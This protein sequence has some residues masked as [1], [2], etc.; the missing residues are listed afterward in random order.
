M[1]QLTTGPAA[2]SVSD[3]SESADAL[4]AATDPANARRL[5]I[6]IAEHWSLLA[7]RSLTYN[8]SLSRVVMFLSVVSAAVVALAL[9][10]QVDRFHEAVTVAA[11][12]ILTVVLFV[13][14]AT[15]VR[16]SAL[17]REDVRSVLGMNRL[18]RAYLDMHP[19]LEQY[20]VTGSH[21]DLPGVMLTMDM[22]MVPDRWSARDTAHAFETLPAMLGVIVAVVAGVLSAVVAA[23]SSAATPVVIVVAAGMFLIIVVGVRLWTGH[24]F[25]TFVRTMS[26]RFPSRPGY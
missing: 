24:A 21:D 7:S 5:Q 3:R 2:T 19:E 1:R 11:I 15:I 6:L 12:L 20:F 17:N 8:E 25:S 14:F 26:T 22:D 16:L 10:A 23:W 4:A 18:R 13:G 9:L